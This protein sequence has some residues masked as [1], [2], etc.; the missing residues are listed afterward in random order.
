MTIAR[1]STF[2]IEV[3]PDSDFRTPALLGLLGSGAIAG[4]WLSLEASMGLAIDPA[5]GLAALAVAAVLVLKACQQH[6]R[7]LSLVSTLL[8]YSSLVVGYSADLSDLTAVS[9]EVSLTG[10]IRKI[11]LW[12]GGDA[13]AELHMRDWNRDDL[14]NLLRSALALNPGARASIP[15]SMFLQEPA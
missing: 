1:V 12:R 6:S 8:V 9:A 10:A 11:T 3:R 5:V 7:R 15:V 4:V 13:V 2:A 14:R